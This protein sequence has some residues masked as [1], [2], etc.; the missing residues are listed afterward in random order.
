VLLHDLTLLLVEWTLILQDR[1][2]GTCPSDVVQ[3]GYVPDDAECVG[4][5]KPGKHRA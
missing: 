3:E 4:G 1:I 5:K 2:R